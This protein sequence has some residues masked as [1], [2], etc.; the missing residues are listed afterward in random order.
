M[1]QHSFTSQL[2]SLA[3]VFGIALA[4]ASCANEDVAQKP[5]NPN[6]DN[7]KNLTTF[8]TGGETRTSMD[9]DSENF[10]WEAGDYI[11]VKDDDGVLQKSTNA[12]T[13]KVASFNYK[14]PGK[15]TTSSSYKVYYLGKNSS[16]N[17][18]SISTAQSQTSPDNTEHFGDAGD[19][20]TATAT[21]TLGGKAFSFVLEHQPAYLVFQ[22]YTSNIVLHD[23][24]LTKVEVSSDND[25]AETYTVNPTTGALVAST[26]TNGK[27]IV[28]TTRGSSNPNGFPLTNSTANV[29]T[30]GAYM[31]IKPG[32][33]T[34]KVRYWVQDLVTYVEG[35]ITKILPSKPYAS[36][37]YYDMTAN[38]N[39]TNY[40]GDHYYM[41]D[42][43]EQYWKGYEWT[44]HLP[45]NTGQPTV[46]D[47]SSP[48][49]A[50]NS[51]DANHR[52]YNESYPGY[53]ISNP[54]THAS[55]K[56]LP[57][58]NELSWYCMYGDP[59]WDGDEL[60]TT[61]GH[62]YK[63]GMWFKKKSILQAGNHYDTEKSA[64][65][66]T[67]LRTTYKYYNNNNNSIYNSGLPSAADAGNYFYLPALGY[68]GSGQLNNIGTNG[69]YWS[70]S[71]HPWDSYGAY[72]L[73]FNGG[74]V[75]VGS[76]DRNGGLRVE[77]TFE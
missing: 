9:Y 20:G 41:W 77:P 22:P 31:V 7:D 52:Y 14:V 72:Y 16:G 64:D 4:F 51:S 59:R 76:Y 43:Q 56:D 62:L 38:L 74:S 60:W 44:K 49:C 66:T 24:Y 5:T 1:K 13:S 69:R 36:N 68:Y 8:V 71:A 50:Q 70:S 6:E 58:A 63:G 48:N 67:D 39:V 25:I 46:R 21:G 34:L 75:S 40:D 29:T 42:A 17:S 11:Y 2:K 35:T 27:Q 26:V 19:Y 54:A 3:V 55:C 57:N 32:T 61:M 28:L 10:Y 12:P 65:N 18:V 53:G 23:C 47:G 33:H 37:T 45:G 15:F 30:N 73:N